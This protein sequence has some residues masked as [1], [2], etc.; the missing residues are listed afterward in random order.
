MI[1]YTCTQVNNKL[2]YSGF[3]SG[4][5]E[6]LS[7]PFMVGIDLLPLLK[8]ATMFLP[9]HERNPEINLMFLHVHVYTCIYVQF[10][11]FT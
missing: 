11:T 10:S 3:I 7:L 9:P 4:G 5:Q 2:L 8:F 1:V 6:V